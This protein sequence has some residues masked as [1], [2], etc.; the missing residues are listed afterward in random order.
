MLDCLRRNE[1]AYWK[2]LDAVKSDAE[3]DALLAKQ[4][5][6][7]NDAFKIEFKQRKQAKLP[8]ESLKELHWKQQVQTL[9][10][11]RKDKAVALRKK[12]AQLLVPLPL[13]QSSKSGIEFDSLAQVASTSELLIGGHQL[14]VQRCLQP[15]PRNQTQY[16]SYC[17]EVE[18]VE[19]A[20]V[21][22]FFAGQLPYLFDAA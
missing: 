22:S 12:I 6:D 21:L 4:I 16:H 3:E 17:F 8:R 10:Q 18:A 14:R 9:R 1:R 20:T 19:L 11:H 13:P 5:K 7:A 15:A 2:V